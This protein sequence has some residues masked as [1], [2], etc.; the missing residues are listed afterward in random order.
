[1]K[2]EEKKMAKQ[3]ENLGTITVLVELNKSLS[4]GRRLSVEMRWD[5]MLDLPLNND[6]LQIDRANVELTNGPADDEVIL[7][8]PNSLTDFTWQGIVQNREWMSLDDFARMLQ[9]DKRVVKVTPIR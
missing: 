3:S 5:N 1:M 9:Q 4:H 7:D 2:T 6:K 8:R